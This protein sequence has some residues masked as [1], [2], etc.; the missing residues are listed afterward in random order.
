MCFSGWIPDFVDA[1]DY[2]YNMLFSGSDNNLVN[3]NNP[4]LDAK[5]EEAIETLDEILVL[6]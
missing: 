6:G 5:I 4:W 2:L 3:V 1:Y